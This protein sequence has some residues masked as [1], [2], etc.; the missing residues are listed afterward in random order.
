MKPAARHKARIYALQSLYAWLLSNNH[1]QE[2]EEYFLINNDFTKVDTEYFVKLF[3]GVTS[4]VDRLDQ[5]MLPF[6]DRPLKE[7]T[8]VELCILRIAIFELI[9]CPDV[10]FRVVINEAVELNKKFG[11]TDGFKYINGVL[12]QVAKKLREQND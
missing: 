3:R 5:Q 10:P 11:S 7:L 8:L 9:E 12:D 4:N 1:S 2:I 6:L